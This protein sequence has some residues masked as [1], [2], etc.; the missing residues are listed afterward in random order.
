MSRFATVAAPGR[1]LAIPAI[2]HGGS[3]RF[4]GAPPEQGFIQE[5]DDPG[6]DGG[7]RKVKYVPG[8]IEARGGDVEQDEI[9]HRPVGEPVDG[10]AEAPR[11]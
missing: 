4:C 5:S 8:E 7:I 10:V 1:R 3:G 6:N 2:H 9:G 11:R